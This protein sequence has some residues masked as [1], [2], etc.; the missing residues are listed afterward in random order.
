MFAN[1]LTLQAVA[2]FGRCCTEMTFKLYLKSL[3][4][5]LPTKAQSIKIQARLGNYDGFDTVVQ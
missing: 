4:R 1:K 2:G 5:I 3:P